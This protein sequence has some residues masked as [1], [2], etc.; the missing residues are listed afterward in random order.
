MSF[1]SISEDGNWLRLQRISSV[2]H[3]YEETRRNMEQ[4]SPL[5]TYRFGRTGEKRTM[6]LVGN[7]SL[8][9]SSRTYSLPSVPR[10]VAA[11]ARARAGGAFA[12]MS[13]ILAAL[14]HPQ[15]ISLFFRF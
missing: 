7:G 8:Q 15:E 4:F 5:C 12:F 1:G 2:L 9:S 6:C 3:L 10:I 13:P 11:R 14:L